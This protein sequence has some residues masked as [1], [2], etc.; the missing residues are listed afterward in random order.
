M[1]N[2]TSKLYPVARERK[3]QKLESNFKK[4]F[5]E[6]AFGMVSDISNGPSASE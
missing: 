1:A 4:W 3:K 5:S 2:N 6:Q